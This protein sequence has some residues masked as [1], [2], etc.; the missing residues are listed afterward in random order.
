MSARKQR[1]IN[2]ILQ[3]IT[4]KI[5]TIWSEQK[6]KMTSFFNLNVNDAFDNVSHFCFLHNLK[7]RRI[8][9]K[10]LKWMKNFLK[11]RNTTLIIE[12]Y[13]MMKRKVSVSISQNSSF[14]LMLYL[15]YNA[16]LLK[17]CKNVKLRFNVIKFVNDINILTYNESMKR[18]C[19]M[20]RKTWNK[21]VEWTKRHGFKFNERKHKLIH[22]SKISKRYNMNANITLKKHQINAST[23]FKILKIQL[24]FKL[25]WESHFHQ[26]KA[27]LLNRHNA[28]NMI[29][30]LI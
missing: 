11:N 22:F 2:T 7:K 16:N 25:R 24:N 17:S 1:S 8:S 13:T 27:K 28:V 20:L 5:H 15:F 6:K 23:D 3:F 26:I 9:N 29:K 19:E 18:N 12:N 21:I 14:F 4:K 10:L 30:N